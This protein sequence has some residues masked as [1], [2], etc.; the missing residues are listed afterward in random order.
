MKKFI[1]INLIILVI[2]CLYF[3]FPYSKIIAT[4][5]GQALE[6]NS[7]EEEKKEEKDLDTLQLEKNSIIPFELSNKSK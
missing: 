5:E 3:T 7:N 2:F 6:E 4:S 1:K